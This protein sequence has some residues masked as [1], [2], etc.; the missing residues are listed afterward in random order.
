MLSLDF[1]GNHSIL[2]KVFLSSAFFVEQE[3][4][5]GFHKKEK[6]S[7]L[8]D[9]GLGL[10]IKWCWSRCLEMVVKCY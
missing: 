7:C 8:A 6:N 3:K 2:G 9:S 5:G 1:P 10:C 4:T